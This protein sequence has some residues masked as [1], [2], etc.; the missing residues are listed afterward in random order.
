M[1]TGE[2][3]LE[4]EAKH[5]APSSAEDKSKWRYTAAPLYALMVW[6]GTTVALPCLAFSTKCSH[7]SNRIIT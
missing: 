2:R 7:T 6:T 3:G 4:H 5:A 1:T